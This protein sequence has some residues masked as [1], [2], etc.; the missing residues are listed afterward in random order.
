[1]VRQLQRATLK[2]DPALLCVAYVREA[3]WEDGLL[4][5]QGNTSLDI[6]N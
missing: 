5:E 4:A 2:F 6:A 1:M 3:S